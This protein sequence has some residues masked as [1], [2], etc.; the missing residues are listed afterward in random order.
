MHIIT[1]LGYGGAEK[2]CIDLCN[3]LSEHNEHQVYLISLFDH[4][5]AQRPLSSLSET[6]IFKSVGKK[7]GLDL[8]VIFKL[9]KLLREIQPDVVHTHLT[10]LF[11]SI[12]FIL[13]NNNRKRIPFIHTLHNPAERDVHPVFNLFHK[14]LFRKKLAKPVAL[15]EE[16]RQTVIAY[17]KVDT[18][19]VINNGIPFPQLSSKYG[20]VVQEIESYKLNAQTKVFINLARIHPQKNQEMLIKVFNKLNDNNVILLIL[21]TCAVKDKILLDQLQ[22]RAKPHIHILGKKD[23]PIDYLAQADAFCLSSH[24]EGL[25]ISLLEALS[26]RKIPICTPVGG[27]PSVISDGSNGLLSASNS[28]ED[29]YNKILHFLNMSPAS[30]TEMQELGYKSFKANFTMAACADAYIKLYKNLL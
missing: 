10:G 28:E 14:Y 26:L 25:P 9:D 11:F 24:Y 21:G 5:P 2:V 3:A 20:T 12:R 6:V 16:I 18:V 8:S 23:N 22:A 30:V 19:A 7:T 27:I 1:S 17:F 29:Y 13:R 15:S 4:T